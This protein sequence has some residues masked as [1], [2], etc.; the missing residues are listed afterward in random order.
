VAAKHTHTNTY[1]MLT[2]V[3]GLCSVLQQIN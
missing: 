2:L 3:Y 1:K